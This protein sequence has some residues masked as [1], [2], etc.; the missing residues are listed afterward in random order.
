MKNWLGRTAVLLAGLVPAA[1]GTV[2]DASLGDS[3]FGATPGGVK[4]MGLARELIDSGRVPPPEAFL[5]EGMFS[6]HDLGLSGPS[7]ARTLCLRTA[8]GSAPTRDNEP[9][10]WLQVGL[11]STVDPATFQRP[12]LT[13]VATV[14]VSGSMGWEYT[15]TTATPG[16]ISKR[17]LQQLAGQLGRDDRLAIVT[18]GSDVS[19]TLSF[20][21]GDQ[22]G[23]IQKAIDNLRSGGSTNMEAG[24]RRAYELAVESEG[25]NPR[26]LLFT[27]EQPN[28]GRT[29]AG[30]FQDMAQAGA[31]KGVGLTVFGAG[32]G[33]G[34]EIMAGM[35]HLRGGNAFSVM[36]LEDADR[37][38]EEEWPWLVT[39]IA[40]DLSLTLAPH[41]GFAVAEAYGFPKAVG[42][43]LP[44]LKVS[45]VFLS[46][47]KGALLVRISSTRDMRSLKVDGT[48]SY[49]NLG[50]RQVKE[51]LTASFADDSPAGAPYF[52]QASVA[53]SVAL[54]LLVSGMHDAAVLYG[55]DREHAVATLGRTV[56]RFASDAQ[57]IEDPALDT[58]VALSRKLFELM[59]SGA[60]QGG[61]YPSP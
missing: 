57:A 20:T 5:V 51:T 28:V 17:L 8:L 52:E 39:P 25:P 15:G 10:G 1:C 34:Q 14:D 24:L 48:L 43:E 7:C 27:D 11:S 21:P 31:E 22:Q 59:Q 61:L 32:R 29:S 4:D 37:V 38:M 49:L 30:D 35:S 53:K 50:Q 41:E 42:G 47:K 45:T 60:E 46:R 13:L 36:D 56:E 26:I 18:Y 44:G 54:A 3:D 19:T 16:A 58:E 23:P 9:A 6:E 55:S 12:A 33:L 40:Y 2:T